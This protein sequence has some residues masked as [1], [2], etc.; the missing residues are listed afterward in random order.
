M[1][2]YGSTTSPPTNLTFYVK[3]LDGKT[4]NKTINISTIPAG[5]SRNIKFS[6][7]N[8]TDGSFKSGFVVINKDKRFREISYKNNARNFG[9]KEI[10][11]SN[12]T[13]NV[14]ETYLVA[15][16]EQTWTGTTTNYTSPLSNQTSIT[17]IKCKINLNTRDLI[18]GYIK[19]PVPGYLHD[20]VT[21]TASGSP[22]LSG[23]PT[24]W[25]DDS[26]TFNLNTY[27]NR[28]NYAEI[29][30]TG[31][32]LES[33]S[34]FK[35][36]I[37]VTRKDY[38]WDGHDWTIIYTDIA[39]GLSRNVEETY[40]G[41]ILNST[42]YTG[43]S[44]SYRVHHDNVTSITVTG[45]PRGMYVAGWFIKPNGKIDTVQA[46]Y[47][48]PANPTVIDASLVKNNYWGVSQKI[49]DVNMIGF[50]IKGNDLKGFDDFRSLGFGAWTWREVY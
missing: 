20:N 13:K 43:T 40:T 24:S 31:S 17:R 44:T 4:L 39:T 23:H 36:P 10:M 33:K 37:E 34:V 30:V 16:S 35:E 47:G 45:D 19:V 5:S 26:C 6:M 29:T 49:K 25:D 12:S 41:T 21:I 28:L 2:N 22:S 3:T 50:I 42:S 9:L 46:I 27:F 1:A 18:V 14:T 38:S 7:C 11:L 15:G 48:D 8:G 32:N